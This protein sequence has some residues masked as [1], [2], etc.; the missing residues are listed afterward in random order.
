MALLEV[1]ELNLHYASPR[2][3]VKAVDAVSFALQ[4]SGHALGIIGETGSGKSSLVMALTRVLP[5]NVATYSGEVHFQDTDLMGLSNDRFRRQVRWKE[6]AVVFQGAMNGFNPVLRIGHQLTERMRLEGISKPA[7]R[8]KAEELLNS[9]GLVRDTYHRYPH[10][11]SGGMKQRVAIAMA[12]T[13]DPALVI[14]DEPTSALDVSVQAQIMNLLKRLKWERGLTMLFVTHDI[15]LASDLSDS[16]AVM[17]AGQIREC[18]TAPEVLGN[19]LDPYTQE[20][21][22]SIPR[23]RGE[24]LPRFVAGAPPDPAQMPRG[25]RFR[26]RCPH[27]YDACDDDPPLFEPSAGHLARCWL[28]ESISEGG[29]GACE[30]GGGR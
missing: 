26:P 15:A 5:G 23:L 8:Q 21:L 3:P 20:L 28:R 24:E 9:V 22:A 11:L 25:C 14:L 16:I 17:Y 2:G 12:L 29:G 13:L 1:R 30:G 4:Q 6:I 19:P 18:G 27:A 7:A 10:E